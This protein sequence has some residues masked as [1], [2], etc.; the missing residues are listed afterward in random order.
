MGALNLNHRHMLG[1]AYLRKPPITEQAVDQWLT[2]LV[3]DIDM[4]ILM[5]PYTINC[6]TVGNEG[7]TG[8]V[9]VE[10]SHCSGH[11]WHLVDRPFLMYDVYSCVYYDTDVVFNNIHEHFD[12]EEISYTLIDRNNGP[13][14]L[15]TGIWYP[16][17]IA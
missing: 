16:K 13:F 10:T 2:K 8:A 11:F 14:V 6:F 1:K 15:D 4:K 5:G 12:V 7:I 17:N 9:V 3:S